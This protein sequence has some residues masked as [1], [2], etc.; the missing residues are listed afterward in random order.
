MYGFTIAH[1]VLTTYGGVRTQERSQ[2]VIGELGAFFKT[3]FRKQL[4]M[5]P[6]TSNIIEERLHQIQPMKN[7]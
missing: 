5:S 3:S 4:L 6:G 2:C 7:P 1:G